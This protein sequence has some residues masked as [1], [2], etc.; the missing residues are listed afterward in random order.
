MNNFFS[1]WMIV[2]W[3]CF[4]FLIALGP[5]LSPQAIY[6]LRDQYLKQG[7]ILVSPS[8][9]CH[10]SSP[11][12][13]PGQL[14]SMALGGWLL[15]GHGGERSS[16]I[17]MHPKQRPLLRR[18]PWMVAFLSNPILSHYPTGLFALCLC[19]RGYRLATRER[20]KPTP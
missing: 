7:P 17:R 2:G 12:S 5:I 15:G 6:F 19:A 1:E 14:L 18:L 11:A 10:G 8:G 9:P 16:T 3:L 13:R 20:L 4:L